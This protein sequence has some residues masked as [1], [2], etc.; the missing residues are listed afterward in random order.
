MRLFGWEIARTKA[1]PPALQP[2]SGSVFWPIV[3]EGR[4]GHWQRNKEI[5]NEVV[6]ANFAVQAILTLIP[7]DV[8]KCRLKLVE[9]DANGIW[10]ET[11]SPAFTPVLKKPN[12]FQNRIQFFENWVLSKLI[13]GNTYVLLERDNRNVVVAMYVL[14]P[15]RTKPLV[16]PDGSVYYQLSRDNLAGIDDGT[17]IVEA[18]QIMHDRWPVTIH[19]LVGVAPLNACKLAADTAESIQRQSASFF[20]NNS[21]PGGIL[22]A[23]GN[24]SEPDVQRIRETWQ[25][26]QGGLNYGSVA[27]MGSNLTYHP[28]A[29]KA[30][31]AQLVEQLASAGK[32]IASAFN[33][34]AY[35]IG[36]G[37]P[38]AHDNV[39]AL[40]QQYYSQC[41]Q[42]IFEAIEELLDEGLGLSKVPGKKYGAEF[43][44]D[45]LFRMDTARLTKA[46]SDG[47]RGGFIAPNEARRKLGYK[48]VAGGETPYL[49]HQDYSLAAL[50]KRDAKEDPFETP[51]AASSAEPANDNDTAEQAAA[52]L[53]EIRKGFA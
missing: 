53:I 39:E 29:M 46:L 7:S 17:F 25:K 27:V 5:R 43:D 44:L 26:K 19:P 10:D 21:Q 12:R 36:V 28:I 42:K 47:V 30:V 15:T 37:E 49:Q 1:A 35:M 40:V 6:L 33:V 16:A 3:R 14:D 52:A 48:P 11:E 8:G 24:I 51:K 4:A 13:F 18:N 2:P 41:L 34:P 23:P 31:D 50:A 20:D 38:P 22:T 32:T 45:N 9:R